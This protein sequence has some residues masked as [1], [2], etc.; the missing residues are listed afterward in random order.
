[1]PGPLYN[2]KGAQ[3]L[4][5]GFPCKATRSP[6]IAVWGP[7]QNQKAGRHCHTGSLIQG[8]LSGKVFPFC[9]FTRDPTRQ[10]LGSLVVLHTT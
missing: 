6:A 3:T 5:S 1:M 9:G 4:P 10:S 7:L 2:H 8:T